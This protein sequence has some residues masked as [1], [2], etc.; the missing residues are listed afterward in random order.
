[1]RLDQILNREEQKM[2]STLLC[3]GIGTRRVE[4]AL[5]NLEASFQKSLWNP[6]DLIEWERATVSW[7][8]KA[9]IFSS[10][11]N[12]SILLGHFVLQP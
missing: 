12:K 4:R 9:N 8:K 11:S 5:D 10:S 7:R 6:G 2:P 3:E 1:M